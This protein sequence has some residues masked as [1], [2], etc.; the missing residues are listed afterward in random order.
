MLCYVVTPLGCFG[1]VGIPH[2]V[3]GLTGPEYC[4][5]IF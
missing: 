5:R 3:S 4:L 2:F 1:R